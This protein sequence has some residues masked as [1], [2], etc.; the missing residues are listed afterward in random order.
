MFQHDLSLSR[1][2]D[3]TDCTVEEGGDKK[4]LSQVFLRQ[5]HRR[6]EILTS[7]PNRLTQSRGIGGLRQFPSHGHIYRCFYVITRTL[8][9][10]LEDIQDCPV[11]GLTNFRRQTV[12][13]QKGKVIT[14][15]PEET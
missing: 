9:R 12:S 13:D 4:G 6:H 14:L 7:Q 15:A 1:A 10:S 5:A 11:C 2:I 3:V 8:Q